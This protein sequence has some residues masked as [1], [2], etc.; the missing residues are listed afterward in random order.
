MNTQETNVQNQCVQRAVDLIVEGVLDA[1]VHH[2]YTFMVKCFRVT[3]LI[4]TTACLALSNL[5]ATGRFSDQTGNRLVLASFILSVR[6]HTTP[7]R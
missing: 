4:L 3:Q 7:L 6:T 1:P 2:E 5:E